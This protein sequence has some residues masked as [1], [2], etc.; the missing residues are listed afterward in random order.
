M[1]HIPQHI[2]EFLRDSAPFEVLDEHEMNRLAQSITVAYFSQ[3]DVTNILKQQQGGL[4]L[5][6]SGQY[7]VKDSAESE[8]HVSDGDYF[9]CDNLWQKQP[10]KIAVTVDSPGLVYCIPK[11]SFAQ[12]VASHPSIEVFFRNYTSEQIYSDHVDDSKSMWLYKPI[13]EVIS[14]GVVSEDI[15]SSILQGVQVMSK[16][17]VSSL[18]ITDNQLLVGILTDR[19]IRNRV[20]AQQTD[21]NL[22]VSEIMTRD[23]V[24]IS[25]QRTLFDA[26]CVMTEHNVHHLPV[27]DKNSGVPLG[28][29]TASDMIR[30]QR[31]NVLFVINEL[32]KA[33]SLYEL[34]RLSWQL[35]HYF[36]KHAKRLGDFD[37]AGKVLSQATDIMTRKLIGFYQQQHG[38]A[39]MEFCW[40]VYGSQAREDQTMGSDQD[41]G[42]LFATEPS[43]EQSAYFA[44]MAEYVCRG[45]DKCGIKLCTGN[46]MASNP[47]LRL[48]IKQAVQQAQSWVR[49]PSP[50]AILNCNIFLDVRAVAGNRFLL[51]QLHVERKELLKQSRF[52][53]ALTRHASDGHVPL[54]MFQKFVYKKGLPK[55]DCIDMKNSG[56]AIIN[57]LVR[58]YSLANGLTMPSIPHRL[59]GLLS[60]AGLSSK[61]VKNL[62][63]IWLF[64][65]RLRWRHQIQNKVTDNYVSISDLSSIEKYQLKEAMR[66]IRRTQ[67]AAVFKFAGGLG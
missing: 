57:N 2:L 24:K 30:H 3:E 43:P 5:I 47:A 25:D 10:N 52:I 27:V 45:L 17:G 33:P 16:S 51:S 14:D 22:A 44:D 31:G 56:V 42:L 15:N 65:N 7:S 62:R 58:I 18:V 64:L 28:M 20:V 1:N 4:F 36:S 67:Q 41:N 66:V 32:T 61:D 63:D 49:E 13:S 46:I 55:K 54:S 39:P 19:D 59:E 53:A 6:C 29:L 12:C 34:T 50:E 35:P 9:G 40:L 38:E 37:I 23:P 8:R 11:K 21:V 60:H 26:L 48:S